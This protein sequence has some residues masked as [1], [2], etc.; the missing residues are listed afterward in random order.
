MDQ[1][2]KAVN[3]ALGQLN[4]GSDFF[5]VPVRAWE[6]GLARR[7]RPSRPVSACSSSTLKLNLVI[8][9]LFVYIAIL[10]HRVSPEFIGSRN[11]VGITFTAESPPA[12]ASSPQGS[13]SNGC[14]LCRS[15]W[16]NYCA[17]LF[18][19]TH[20]WYEVGISKVSEEMVNLVRSYRLLPF[21]LF[22]TTGR[23]LSIPST[24]IGQIP[25]S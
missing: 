11:C 22:S 16:T 12:R 2:G 20:Y 14:C 23:C 25:S 18:S 17:L 6:F 3:S 9:R 21:L 24:V 5:P 10:R 4:K 15:S 7:V 13:S 8:R 1:L 19:H